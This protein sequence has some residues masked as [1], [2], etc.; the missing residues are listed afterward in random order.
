MS[1]T[2]PNTVYETHDLRIFFQHVSGEPAM[3]IGSRHMNRKRAYVIC[4]S[5]A[6]QYADSETLVMKSYKAADVLGLGNTRVAAY[7][8]ADAILNYLPELIKMVPEEEQS[9]Q[10]LIEEAVENHGLEIS[11]GGQKVVH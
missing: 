3:C 11:I 1:G 9:T 6:W 4:L 7:K 8:I 5:S 10:D 2:K